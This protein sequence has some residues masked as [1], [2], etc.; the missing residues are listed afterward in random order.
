MLPFLWHKQTIPRDMI[1]PER[2]VFRSHVP[3]SL[4]EERPNDSLTECLLLGHQQ[5]KFRKG[6]AS[7]ADF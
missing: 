7:W 1:L 4:R 5:H 2:K 3:V 6:L